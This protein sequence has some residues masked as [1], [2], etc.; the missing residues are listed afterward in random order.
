MIIE[1]LFHAR[2]LIGNFYKSL[3]NR[4]TIQKVNNSIN[5]NSDKKINKPIADLYHKIQ[6]TNSLA[7]GDEKSTNIQTVDKIYF[8]PNTIAVNEYIECSNN[9]SIDQQVKHRVVFDFT[10]FTIWQIDKLSRYFE[11][12]QTNLLLRGIWFLNIIKEAEL[13]NKKIAIVTIDESNIV[14]DI[15]PINIV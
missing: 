15:T 12:S 9:K 14:T 6:Q 8:Q 13:T 4:T 1:I 2:T 7:T 10:Q 3:Q 5:V 11:V